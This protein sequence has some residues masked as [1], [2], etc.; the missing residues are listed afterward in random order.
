MSDMIFRRALPIAGLALV[1]AT[2]GCSFLHTDRTNYQN[3][4]ETK[5]LEV[6]PDLD[7]PPSASELTIPG[8]GAG[9]APRTAPVATSSNDVPPSDTPTSSTPRPAPGTYVGTETTLVLPDEAGSAWKRVALALE[10]SGV[11][12]VAGRDEAAG[13]VTLKQDTVTKEGGFF[14]RM[15]GRGGTKTESVTR[16]VRISAE[17]AGSRVRVEDESGRAIEDESARE[18]IAAIKQR[19]G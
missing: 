8:S 10:R 17:G 14:K 12:S 11:M 16:V 1:L 18:I 3:S 15:I 19:L 2:S 7:S 13:T 9:A 4:H 5:P 6:P